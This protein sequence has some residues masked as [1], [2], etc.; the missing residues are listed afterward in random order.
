MTLQSACPLCSSDGG[1]IV[2]QNAVLRVVQVDD[3]AY[4]GFC[5]VIWNDHIAELSDL[6]LSERQ[7][8]F[9]VLVRVEQVVREQMQPD[10]INLASFGNQVPHLHWHIIP[11]FADDAHFPQA[12][13]AATVREVDPARLASHAARAAG[14]ATALRAALDADK[15]SGDSVE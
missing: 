15:Y 13:W 9:D 2:W 3:A 14:L 5:R 8:L 12:V 4:P 11:R 7:V 6:S 1:E 10:K